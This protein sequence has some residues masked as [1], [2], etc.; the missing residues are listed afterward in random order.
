M[1]VLHVMVAGPYSAPT[2][3]GRAANLRRMNE[4]A[5]RVAGLG[6]VP[7]V[8]VNAALPVLEAAGLPYTHP[9]MM[10]ISLALAARCDACLHI[11]RSPGAD[12]E[13]AAF[14]ARGLPVWTRIEDVP[15]AE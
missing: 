10:D 5:A 15:R 11:A 13:A 7:V 6:H 12:R 8:G 1:P 2:A 14:A 3:E 4:A 9:W